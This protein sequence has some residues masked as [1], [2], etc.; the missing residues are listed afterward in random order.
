MAAGSAKPF[1]GTIG[2]TVAGSKPWW[3]SAPKPPEGAPNILVVL[4]DDVGFS[5]FG[6]YGSAIRTPTIDKLAAEGLR[7]S[8]FH[9]TAMCS[10][11]R[12]ALLTGR[13]HHS[14]GVGCLANFDSGYPGYRGK[15]AREAGTLAEMLRPHGYRN[16]MVGKWHVTP[17]TESGA[18]GPFDGWPLGRGFDRFYG[19]LDA[20]TDQFAPELVSDNTHV[21]PPGTYADGYHL[22]SDLVD[23]SIR[24]IADHTADRPD[25]PWLTWVALGACHAPHQAPMDIIKSYDAKFAHGWDVEREQR[26]ARQKAMGIVPQETRLPARNDGV[27][28]W[29]EHSADEKR[30][31]T[32]LQAAFAGML[33]HADQHLARLIGFLDTAG[34]RDNTLILVLSDNGASQEGGPFGFV[35]AMGPYN[36]R[37]EPIA[38]KLRRID[39]IGGPDSHSNFPH[40]WAMASNT[41][42]RRYKQNTHGGGIRDP[43]VMTWPKKIAAKGEVRHQFVHACDLTPTLL[44]LIGI[45]PPAEIGGVAQMPIEGESFAR[46]ISGP[47]RAVKIVAAIF[48]DVRASR[49]LAGRLEGGLLP[50][51]GHAVRERQMGAVSPRRRI[52]RKPMISRRQQP[53]RLAEM[54]KLWWSEA[55]KHNVLPLDDR[56]GPRFAENAA[57]FHGARNKFTFHAGMGHVPTDVAPDVRSRSYTIEAHVEIGE[58]GAEGVLIAHGDATSGY[59]LYI[60]DGLLVHD[61]NIG[62]GHEIVTSNRKVP[63]GAHRLGVHVERLVRKE[64]PAK[65][66]RTGVTRLHAAD[67][68]RAGR[69]DP[70]PAGL[71]QFHLVVRPRHRPRP[72]QPGLALRG[73]V[74]IH[75]AVAAGDGR[76]A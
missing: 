51:L 19:F 47:I 42:L 64:P 68:R 5:D 29:E 24:F 28:A 63:S 71:Q 27:K 50:S 53:E 3:P 26:M 76:H 72:F 48:R 2:K 62:G 13:N 22:T 38:E 70:D 45:A 59:S 55:E 25:I 11:T 56:F 36:F 7:Y 75:R 10:T 30:V 9:T 74:R 32:R 21:D 6:C 39:D 8:G 57:R 58:D 43:F 41:P 33:D 14:V 54:I 69:L 60:K 49:A 52:F 1:G 40:G 66:S 23:Q 46:S 73:A 34:I 61:L 16:Y 18:T 17:L 44:D 67:R 20:E 15:I 4:F 37:P 35:N 12:A 31:F 65:G